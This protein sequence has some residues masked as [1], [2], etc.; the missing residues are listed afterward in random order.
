MT[1]KVAVI[2][3]AAQ[4]IG[5]ATAEALRDQGLTVVITDINEDGA[6]VAAKKLGCNAQG[7]LCDVSP[8]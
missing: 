6:K 8:C 4:G 5:Y 7:Y 1:Q 3:G 2:T